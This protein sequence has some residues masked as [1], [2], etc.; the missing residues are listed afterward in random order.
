V[1]RSGKRILL[2]AAILASVAGCGYHL[3]GGGNGRFSDPA[4][5]IDV[6]PFA[7]A[8]PIP[9]AGPYIAARLREELRRGGFRGAFDKTGADFLVEG[10][11]REIRE[12]VVARATDSRFGLE[13]RLTLLVDIRVVEVA[14]GR[15]LWKEAGLAETA[16]FYSDPDALF[17]E[18]N[19]TTAFEEAGRRMAVRI[20]QTIKVAL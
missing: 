19:R 3:Q 20:A 8:S 13:Y 5:R 15:V 2:A 11:I 7:N 16:P 12:D 9:G 17:T 6:S 18:A 10:K 1:R 14:K 4:T